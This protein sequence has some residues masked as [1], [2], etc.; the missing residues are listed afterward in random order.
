[1]AIEVW[2]IR[3]PASAFV[4]AHCESV[5]SE[6]ERHRACRFRYE[7]DHNAY[8]LS[9]GILRH[10]LGQRLG[11]SA[12][13]IEF[14]IRERGKP[15]LEGEDLNFN[16][17][18]SANR[19]MIAVA[20]G[21]ELGVDIQALD[22]RVDTTGIANRYF[23]PEEIEF[24]LSLPLS[25]QRN[26]FFQL[27]VRKEAYCKAIGDGLSIPLNSFSVNG[28]FVSPDWQLRDLQA[29]PDYVAA[30]AWHGSSQPII[31]HSLVHPEAL[32]GYVHELLLQPVTSE[33]S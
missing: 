17:S 14:R 31:Q 29:E 16:L 13:T 22:P 26:A 12:A 2:T 11:T 27:W 33:S 4:L 28:T 23:H 1:M 19:I 8:V 25:Q 3:T 32:E 30:L 20:H 21:C 10:L 24:L 5:L 9:H 18:H 15:Y 7:R 6:E